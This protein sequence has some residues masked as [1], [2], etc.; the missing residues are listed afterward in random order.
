MQDRFKFRT[1][2]HDRKFFKF[3]GW[4]NEGEYKGLCPT[5]EDGLSTLLEKYTNQC[6]GK[7][8]C[9]GK[10]IYENDIITTTGNNGMVFYYIV[11]YDEQE[12]KW[13]LVYR[14]SKKKARDFY[15]QY[16]NPKDL[17]KEGYRIVGNVF[18]NPELL[19]SNN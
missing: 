4:I 2:I 7:K 9:T 1:Y 18:Q 10:L 15:K 14:H 19:E 5:G 3:W 6:T 17:Y 16:V 13:I 8:D 12:Y 11:K